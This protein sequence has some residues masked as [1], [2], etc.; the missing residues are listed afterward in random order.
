MKQSK[1]SENSLVISRKGSKDSWKKKAISRGSE[2]IRLRKR[3]KELTESRDNWKNKCLDLKKRLEKVDSFRVEG[4]DSFREEKASGHKYSLMLIWLVVELSKY[5]SLSL[6]GCRHC[7]GC[8]AVNLGLSVS[9]PSHTSIRNWLLKVGYHRV[10]ETEKKQGNY[11][12]YV[13][14]SIVFG[15][16][17]ILLILGVC[18]AALPLDRALRHSDMEVLYVGA[19]TEWTGDD[20]AAELGKIAEVKGISYVVSDQGTNLRKAYKLLNYTHIE[21]CTHILANHIKRAY[22]SDPVF[23]EFRELIGKLR[24]SWNLSKQKSR[25]MPPSMRGK[26]RFAN[27]FPCVNW[28]KKLLLDWENLKQDVQHSLLFLKK[29]AAFIDTLCLVEIIF[30][31]TCE[32]LKNQG[33]GQKQ[34]EIIT[35]KLA[36]LANKDNQ[37]VT[38]LIQ[39]CTQYLEN[40]ALKTK[41]LE[42]INIACS[43][44]IIESFFGKFKAK[45]NPN[46]STGL[47]EFIFTIANFSQPFSIQEI[48]LA[49]QE[50]KI[51]HINI[52]KK[53]NN[54]A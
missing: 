11:L 8:L 37:K 30:K 22:E 39:N 35:A 40:L 10:A 42:R 31:S 3:Q 9:I 32:T 19:S 25:Y 41:E 50:V 14:E 12:A 13:D 38:T 47:T 34:K 54:A 18:E 49:L 24:K 46:N 28:A 17:K 5:G 2:N 16:E 6:R 1:T 52:P 27:I 36:T 53:T 44:D 29:N 4:V 7:L 20:I 48:K 15:S 23:K 51:K 33:F 21:D 26:L 45:I 43:S